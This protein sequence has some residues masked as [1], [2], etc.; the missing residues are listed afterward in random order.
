MRQV[1]LLAHTVL[2]A[3]LSPQLFADCT[4][5]TD[6]Y[7]VCGVPGYLA[8][9]C[10]EGPKKCQNCTCDAPGCREG[11]ACCCTR[12]SGTTCHELPPCGQGL[13]PGAPLP[14]DA[15]ADMTEP[16][17]FLR[18]QGMPALSDP[19]F[20]WSSGGAGSGTFKIKN[21]SRTGLMAYA[22]RWY[23][24]T[25]AGFVPVSTWRDNWISGDPLLPAGVETQETFDAYVGAHGGLVRQIV[26]EVTYAQYQD[27]T[28]MGDQQTA[29]QFV[30]RRETV[31]KTYARLRE[32]FYSRGVDAFAEELEFA[33]RES[34]PQRGAKTRLREI[35]REQ[36]VAA[37]LAEIERVLNRPTS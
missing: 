32:I 13:A 36:G 35:F 7:T 15:P 20:A 1:S 31:R 12:Q 6:C 10:Y 11:G 26:A 25:T 18:R 22:I 34:P 14:P 9:K 2:F 28:K 37:A 19:S 8:C 21:E 17:V 30:E 33:A 16:V 5:E 23:F 27:G 4:A 29:L 3:V 24:R